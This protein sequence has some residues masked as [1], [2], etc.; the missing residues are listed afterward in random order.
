MDA[1]TTANNNIRS[2]HADA[3]KLRVVNHKYTARIAKHARAVRRHAKALIRLHDQIRTEAVA[4]AG[5]DYARFHCNLGF[6]PL[7]SIAKQS[8]SDE[9]ERYVFGAG[10]IDIYNAAGFMAEDAGEFAA[11]TRPPKLSSE[12]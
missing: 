10:L 4:L 7:A 12:L 1:H 11:C 8:N 6:E 5:P 9:W 2:H 3:L